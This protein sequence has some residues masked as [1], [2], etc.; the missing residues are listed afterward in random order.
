MTPRLNTFVAAFASIVCQWVCC[1][2]AIGA[3]EALVSD[4]SAYLADQPEAEDCQTCPNC[5]KDECWNDTS[6]SCW[7]L[8]AD[9]LFLHRSRA[10]SYPVLVDAISGNQVFN[11]SGLSFGTQA[12]PRIGLQRQLASGRILDVGYFGIEGW[13]SRADFGPGNY[14]LSGDRSLSGPP[15]TTASF[16]YASSLHSV[17]INVRSRP[18]GWLQPL[19]GFRYLRLDETYQVTGTGNFGIS[20]PYSLTYHTVNDLFG[21]QI[22]AIGRVWDRGGPFTINLIGKTG[23]Y[24]N[25][26]QN[27]GN[28]TSSGVGLILNGLGQENQAAFF[29]ELGL[30]ATLRLTEHWSVRGGYQMFWLNGVGLAPNQVLAT[31]VRFQTGGVEAHNQVFFEG[32]N[33]GLQANW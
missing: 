26:V 12:G 24:L 4:G 33:I 7:V 10:A 27:H 11:T 5:C 23:L 1:T 17:E 9:A 22:G 31:D 13:N 20:V 3:E 14:I 19:A 15:A 28:F 18:G 25:D 16:D 6:T 29:S 21:G 8:T 32:A 2:C 30:L